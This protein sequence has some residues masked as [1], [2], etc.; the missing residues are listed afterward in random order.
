MEIFKILGEEFEL[1]C[2]K[3]LKTEKIPLMKPWLDR[4]HKQIKR[5]PETCGLDYKLPWMKRLRTRKK[6]SNWYV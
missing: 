4:A 1:D 5:L 3:V 2:V 6:E